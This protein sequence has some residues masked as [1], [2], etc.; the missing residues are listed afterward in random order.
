[1][2]TYIYPEFDQ[3]L[4]WLYGEDG[5]NYLDLNN[6]RTITPLQGILTKL[7][8]HSHTMVIYSQCWFHKIPSIA[9]K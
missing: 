2:V 4:T 1:M 6:Q 8:V 9:Y 5:I 3:L 7:H